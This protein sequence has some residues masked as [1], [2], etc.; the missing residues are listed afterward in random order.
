MKVRYRE[1]A[2]AD[3]EEIFRYIKRRNPNGA[4]N[5]IRAIFAGVQFLAENP[6]AAPRTDDPTVRVM[7]VRQYR[8]KVFYSINDDE[9]DVLHIRHGAR[10]PWGGR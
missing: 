5:V 7:V 8:Y 6:L 9:I 2:R 1:R 4:Q 10:R 3:I